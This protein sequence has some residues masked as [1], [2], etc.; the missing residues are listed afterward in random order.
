MRQINAGIYVYALGSY[1]HKGEERM[2]KEASI[3]KTRMSIRL[4]LF[5]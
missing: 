3:V 5:V 4:L 1:Q 2:R